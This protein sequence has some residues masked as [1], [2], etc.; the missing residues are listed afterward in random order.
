MLV[1]GGFRDL[2]GTNVS[3]QKD[4][5]GKPFARQLLD[6][7]QHQASGWIDYVWPRP[8]TTKPLCKKLSYARRTTL[9]GELII[10]GAG[11]YQGCDDKASARD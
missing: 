8:G 7:M 1:N 10:V 9:E 2:E 3:D 11:V 6:M 5:N 4:A